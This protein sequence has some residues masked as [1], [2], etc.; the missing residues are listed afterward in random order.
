MRAIGVFTTLAAIAAA[1]GAV[2]V[3]VSSRSDLQRYLRIR[4]M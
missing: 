4:N 2:I 3:L 1:V